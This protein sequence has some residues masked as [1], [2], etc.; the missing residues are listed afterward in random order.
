VTAQTQTLSEYFEAL[1]RLRAGRPIV[2]PKGSKITN[3]SVA[4]EA[5]RGKGSIKKSRPV[6]SDLIN[7]IDEAAAEQSSMSPE[8]QQKDQLERVKGT[9]QQRRKDLEAI[10]AALVSRLVE[11]HELKKQVRILEQQVTDLT[12]RLTRVSTGKVQSFEPRRV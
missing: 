10:T 7:A 1:A 9:S 5:G 8:R 12:E 11:V 4:L 3:D 6:F 2:V